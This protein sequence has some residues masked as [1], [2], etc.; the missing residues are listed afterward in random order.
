MNWLR[1]IALA[2]LGRYGAALRFPHLML[3]AGAL[4]VL[5]FVIP[6]AI[7]F[8]D[9]VFL[10]LATL[11]FAAWRKRGRDIET[12]SEDGVVGDDAPREALSGDVVTGEHGT[13]RTG[14][15]GRSP[16]S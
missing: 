3:L 2:L 1:K 15:G 11:M 13:A 16:R 14:G 7:P 8:V 5:D 12:V 6:D 10:G 4:F 9:E